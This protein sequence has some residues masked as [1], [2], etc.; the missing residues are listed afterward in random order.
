MQAPKKNFQTTISQIQEGQWGFCKY[1]NWHIFFFAIYGSRFYYS[2]L[3]VNS[4]ASKNCFFYPPGRADIP[5]YLILG[6]WK[7]YEK[8]HSSWL[9]RYR[10]TVCVWQWDRGRFDQVQYPRWNML[11]MPSFFYRQ[12]ETDWHSGSYWTVPE[13][14]WK[15]SKPSE[16]HLDLSCLSPRFAEKKSGL[17][18]A[19]DNCKTVS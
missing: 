11:Q 17:P 9:R 1:G 2:I 16:T 10:H 4:E 14:V 18:A 13:K 7:Y 15:I 8:R 12:T 5:I 3:G 6:G 19:S